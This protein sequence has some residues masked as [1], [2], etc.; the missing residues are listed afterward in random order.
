MDK[1]GFLLAETTIKVVIAIICI[2]F[3]VFLGYKLYSLTA[4]TEDLDQAEANMDKIMGI[5]ESLEKQGS[6][7][8]DYV[9]LSPSGWILIGWPNDLFASYIGGGTG[10]GG[11]SY[12]D[13]GNKIPN[14]CSENGWS[15]CI[16]LCKYDASDVLKKCD[17]QGVCRELNFKS[18]VNVE[19]SDKSEGIKVE[20]GKDLNI[21]LEKNVLKIVEK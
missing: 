17:E 1:K 11:Y 19:G 10:G 5:I 18:I 13:Y 16:C 4:A 20:T 3:L 12:S 6:G 21:I 9:L 14:V 15:K 2:G 8:A 7:S